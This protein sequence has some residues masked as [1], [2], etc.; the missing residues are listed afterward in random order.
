[1]TDISSGEGPKMNKYQEQA[2]QKRKYPSSEEQSVQIAAGELVNVKKE[3]VE[4]LGDNNGSIKEPIV[5]DISDDDDDEWQSWLRATCAPIFQNSGRVSFDV[6]IYF[7][8]LMSSK[9]YV[10]WYNNCIVILMALRIY[11]LS[12]L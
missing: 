11:S 4:V 5:I 1:M 6:L 10:F 2:G 12:A 9:I 7:M 8:N 3:T